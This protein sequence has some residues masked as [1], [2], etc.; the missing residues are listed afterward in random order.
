MRSGTEGERGLGRTRRICGTGEKKCSAQKRSFL[1]AETGS[2][3][4]RTLRLLVLLAK[5]VPGGAISSNRAKRSC[6]VCKFST[7]ASMMRS[8]EDAASCAEVV[9]VMLCR[10]RSMYSFWAAGSSGDFLR[11]IRVSDLV[12]ME[13]LRERRRAT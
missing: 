8:G 13:R 3:I 2:A 9:V 7:I 1:A 5:I 10:T 12:M 4:L 11:A 6:F